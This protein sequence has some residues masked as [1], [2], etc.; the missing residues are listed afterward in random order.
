[1][2][3][4]TLTAWKD[5]DVDLITATILKY[6]KPVY[7]NEEIIS[8]LK[9]T[10]EDTQIDQKIKTRIISIAKQIVKGAGDFNKSLNPAELIEM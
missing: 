1:M 2:G 5:K 7:S 10:P 4:N 6:G 9:T 8:I 3:V